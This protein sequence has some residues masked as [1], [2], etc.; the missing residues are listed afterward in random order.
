MEQPPSWPA[1]FSSL[2]RYKGSMVRRFPPEISLASNDLELLHPTFLPLAVPRALPR[3]RSSLGPAHIFSQSSSLQGTVDHP[4]TLSSTSSCSLR[5]TQRTRKDS[6]FHPPP[7]KCIGKLPLAK[8]LAGAWMSTARLL[9]F[10][11]TQ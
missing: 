5:V 4:E 9:S 2:T 3:L 6:G 8:T 7:Q 1:V 10:R 11:L